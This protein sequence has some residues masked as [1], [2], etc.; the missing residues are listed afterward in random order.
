MSRRQLLTAAVP[1]AALGVASLAGPAEAAQGAVEKVPFKLTLKGPI[2]TTTTIPLEPP[3]FFSTRFPLA[4]PS[5]LFGQ[6]VY[7]GH[8]EGYLDIEGEAAFVMG[9]GVLTGEN[10]DALFVKWV[11]LPHLTAAGTT[12][13]T[14]RFVVTGGSGKYSNTGGS[15]A[16]SVL[17][18]PARNQTT[19]VYDGMLAVRV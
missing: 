10:G 14:G 2:P 3:L 12:E 17:F 1:A 7:A 6:V 13:A 19:F 11:F 8:D 18:E 15:G 5:T 9:E 16:V 4:G